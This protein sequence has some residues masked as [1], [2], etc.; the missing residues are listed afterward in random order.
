MHPRALCASSEATK[1]RALA[2]IPSIR[3]QAGLPQNRAALSS[4][5]PV[6]LPPVRRAWSSVQIM[7][8]SVWRCSLGTP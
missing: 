6:E 5:E 4:S 1:S 3:N 2:R 7:R 8:R